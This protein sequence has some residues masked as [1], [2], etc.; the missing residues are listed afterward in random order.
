MN[1]ESIQ[2]G[3]DQMW[4]VGKKDLAQGIVDVDPIPDATSK[5]WGVSAI[6]RIPTIFGE[7]LLPLIDT[8][9]TKTGSRH[10]FHDTATFHVTLRSIEFFRKD[11]PDGDFA[12]CTY[13]KLLQELAPQFSPFGIRFAGLSANRVGIILQGYPVDAQI[14]LFRQQVHQH[15]ANHQFLQGP[16][17]QNPRLNTHISLVVFGGPLKNGQDLIQ[18][19]DQHRRTGYGQMEASSIDLVRYE[20]DERSVKIVTLD[21]FAL[22]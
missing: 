4:M 16:E 2:T 6:L 1:N 9:K 12:V 7:S 17:Q 15:L 13:S 19:V 14:Q 22:G 11:V 20:R 5:R 10:T 8:L 18:Y 3:Y 21:R